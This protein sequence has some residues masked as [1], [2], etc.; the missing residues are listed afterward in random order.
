MIDYDSG[1]IIGKHNGLFGYT[2]GQASRICHGS[3]KWFVAQKLLNEAKIAL[4]TEFEFKKK[5]NEALLKEIISLKKIISELRDKN[6]KSNEEMLQFEI[7]KL[8]QTVQNKI[9][10]IDKLKEDNQKLK[11]QVKSYEEN[12]NL[13][14]TNNKL[15]REEAEKRFN[16]YQKEIETLR[17]K[18]FNESNNNNIS[19]KNTNSIMNIHHEE[20]ICDSGIHNKS[21]EKEKDKIMVNTD[22]INGIPNSVQEA[23]S[24][25]EN[26][27]KMNGNIYDETKN[28][29]HGGYKNVHENIIN[30]NDEN[31]NNSNSIV[32]KNEINKEEENDQ[33]NIHDEINEIEKKDDINDNRNDGLIDKD[34]EIHEVKIAEEEPKIEVSLP[35]EE[36]P[37]KQ[38]V[39]SKPIQPIIPPI[40]KQKEEPKKETNTPFANS[41]N[42]KS[43]N[44]NN[45]NNIFGSE[46]DNLN[47]NED[48]ND[49][50]SSKPAQVAPVKRVKPTIPKAIT[51]NLKEVKQEKPNPF[52]PKFKKKK[53]FLFNEFE[54]ELDDD[55]IFKKD[56]NENIFESSSGTKTKSI[57]D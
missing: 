57:F 4:K 16:L 10:E 24:Y 41:N 15:F 30:N 5:E 43:A 27:L 13:M 53:E 7:V 11:N 33:V 37:K 20:F 6:S 18:A 25:D 31:V 17:S 3:N 8:K 45:N 55:D 44:T 40:Q 38:I 19:H 21:I 48:V 32:N 50:F 36:P 2:I 42:T 46:G 23:T 47:D 9:N 54:N 14:K 51:Q 34:N 52:A 28:D 35:K 29:N 1:K 22:F 56:G 26:Y 39:E 49:I 12:F